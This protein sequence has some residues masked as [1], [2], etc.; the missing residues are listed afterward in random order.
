MIEKSPH[1]KM[2][3]SGLLLALFALISCDML[4]EPK[5]P[6]WQNTIEFPLIS[7]SVNLEDLEDEDN[8]ITQLYDANGEKTIFAYA[9]TTEMDSQA[10]GDQLAFGD[11]TQSFAQSVDD[12]TVTGSSIN[13]TSAFEPVGVDPIQKDIDSELGPIELSDIPATSTDPFLLSEIFPG[14]SALLGQTTAIAGGD[15]EP[16]LKPFEFT[17]FSCGFITSHYRHLNIH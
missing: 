12:V 14:V 15:L 6:T 13:Q 4:Q 2:Q 11:I 1:R 17:D 16:V 3:Y 7:E 10:V 5:P 8:I 9:D